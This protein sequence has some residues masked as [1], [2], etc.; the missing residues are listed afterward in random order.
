M[1]LVAVMALGLVLGS[2]ATGSPGVVATTRRGPSEF[3]MLPESSQV[4]LRSAT[5]GRLL[6]V[7]GTWGHDVSNS[8]PLLSP[9]GRWIYATL[10]R[11]R[12]LVVER[13]STV[14]GH[15]HLISVGETPALSPDNRYL[16]YGTGRR[17]YL[18]AIRDLRTGR[19]RL[20][21]LEARIG[22][23]ASLS[24]G[25]TSITWLSDSRL[26]VIPGADGVAT[27][28]ASP[29]AP[30]R[31]GRSTCSPLARRSC[32]IVVNLAGAHPGRDAGVAFGPAEAFVVG[33]GP[34]T[35]VVLVTA[36]RGDGWVID[37]TKISGS[38]ERVVG[39]VPISQASVPLVFDPDGR[40]VLYLRGHGPISLWTAVI[41]SRRLAHAH[42]LVPN[43][44]LDGAGW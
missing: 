42:V 13:F 4:Q 27:S 22:P 32:L 18:L 9:D 14:T 21:R 7:V 30:S 26:V 11:D 8:S 40:H 2:S 44:H 34:T 38:S 33:A 28:A 43:V 24:N 17:G 35:N 25:G 39:V 31:S 10:L 23:D 37:R 6:K 36:P 12:R 15:G 16:A 1:A 41:G 29:S 20:I 3:V 19:T 5:S